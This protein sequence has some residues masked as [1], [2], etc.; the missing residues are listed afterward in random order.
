V[1]GSGDVVKPA[2]IEYMMK[3][4]SR[5]TAVYLAMRGPEGFSDVSVFVNEYMTEAVAKRDRAAFVKFVRDALAQMT[6]NKFDRAVLK[7]AT[8]A[9][10]IP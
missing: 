8:A 7:H 10:R 1:F 6:R 3:L 2:L 4:I 5:R 9:D